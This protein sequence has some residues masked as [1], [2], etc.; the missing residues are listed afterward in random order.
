MNILLLGSGGREHALAWKLK[1]SKYCKQL[2]IAPGNA[3]TAQYG[4]NLP[5]GVNDFEKVATACKEHLIDM[6]VVGSEE[7]LVNGIRDY[8]ENDNTV[9]SLKIIGPGK[10]GAQLEG[11]KEF[12]KAFMQRHHIPTAAYASF[13]KEILEEGKQYLSQHATPIVLKADGLAAGKG[14]V[15]CATNEEAVITFEEMIIAQKFGTAGNKVVVE[16]FLTGIEMSVFVIA[17]GED[18]VLLPNAKDYKKIGVGE[19]GLNTGGMGAISPVPFCDELLF[20]K[21]K[22]EIIE[23]TVLGLKKENIAYCGIIF[24]GLIVKNGNAKVIEYNCRLGDPET[25][26]ILPRLENDLVEIFNATAKGNLKNIIIKES[27]L[28]AAG[29][30]A[31]S[32]GYPGDYAKGYNI[33]LT[34]NLGDNNHIFYAGIKNTDEKLV[35]DGGRV[36]VAVSLAPTLQEAAKKSR[37]ILT[38]TKFEGMYFRND[39]GFEFEK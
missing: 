34:E 35:T 32:G 25:E 12:S 2:F 9:S 20:E 17:D 5:V 1:Q 38:K 26:V 21:I 15:I 24:I 16:E 33:K 19:T 22:K 3:G 37:E 18:Y 31:V 29:T 14:V 39:I 6:L 10:E 4:I 28:H 13:T 36:L 7:P 23:P 11:S 27:R 30:V 8:L